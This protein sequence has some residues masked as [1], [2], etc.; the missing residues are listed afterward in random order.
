MSGK[1]EED[2]EDV[3][4]PCKSVEEENPAGRILRDEEVQQRQGDGVTGEHVVPAGTD[5]LPNRKKCD[6]TFQ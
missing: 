3:A 1:D 2:T 4:D 5:T 6:K